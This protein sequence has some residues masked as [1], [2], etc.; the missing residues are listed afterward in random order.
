MSK[1]LSVS[2]IDDTM[3]ISSILVTFQDKFRGKML[4]PFKFLLTQHASYLYIWLTL[5]LDKKILDR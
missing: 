3:E 1:F 2:I 4:V 5:D